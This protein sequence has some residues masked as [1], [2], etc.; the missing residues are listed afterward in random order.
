MLLKDPW[1]HVRGHGLRPPTK[2]Y[3]FDLKTPRRPRGV[4]PRIKLKT[5][6]TP[7][8]HKILY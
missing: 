2:I 4:E 6:L 5:N 7:N 8:L 1:D 3:L